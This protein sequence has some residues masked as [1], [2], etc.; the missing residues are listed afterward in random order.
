MS[1]GKPCINLLNKHIFPKE[2][3]GLPKEKLGFLEEKLRSPKEIR[4][5]PT[6]NLRFKRESFDFLRKSFD[7][8][9]KYQ[10]AFRFPKENLAEGRGRR[11]RLRPKVPAEGRDSVEAVAERRPWSKAAGG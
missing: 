4:R 3:L 11:Q 7:F 6:E 1:C 5:F 2:I 8:L 10:N 9:R